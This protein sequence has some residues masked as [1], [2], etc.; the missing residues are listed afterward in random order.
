MNRIPMM[1]ITT[2]ELTVIIILIICQLSPWYHGVVVLFCVVDV[3]VETTLG[4]EEVEINPDVDD[5]PEI[6]TRTE[7]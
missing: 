2:R 3:I 4:E 6:I 5:A 7:S 1:T